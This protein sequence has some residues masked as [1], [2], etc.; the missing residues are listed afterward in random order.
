MLQPAACRV[1][2]GIGICVAVRLVELAEDIVGIFCVSLQRRRDGL[3]ANEQL[4]R[5]ACFPFHLYP[6]VI[7][8]SFIDAGFRASAKAQHRLASPLLRN[9][10]SIGKRLSSSR[11]SAD[12]LIGDLF[13]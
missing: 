1:K 3:Q 8:Q 10:A 7:R 12:N 9:W 4:Y 5:Q 13:C 11:N 2:S 6:L